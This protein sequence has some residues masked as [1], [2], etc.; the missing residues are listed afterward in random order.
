MKSPL[1]TA[2]PMWAHVAFS[3]QGEAAVPQGLQM[4]LWRPRLALAACAQI[5]VAGNLKQAS[6]AWLYPR[7]RLSI[8]HPQLLMERK[9]KDSLT[10]RKKKICHTKTPWNQVICNLILIII[11]TVQAWNSWIYSIKSDSCHY[12]MHIAHVEYF[13]HFCS[14][15][16]SF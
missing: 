6:K 15:S 7:R 2:P 8:G 9:E 10:E 4:C 13:L 12:L 1:V 16:R 5:Q 11:S 14:N 3:S